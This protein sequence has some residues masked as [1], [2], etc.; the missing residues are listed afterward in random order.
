MQRVPVKHRNQFPAYL[1]S[2]N[3]TYGLRH[4]RRYPQRDEPGWRGVLYPEG[5]S[6]GDARYGEAT[7]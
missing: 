5:C 1:A 6:G 3:V 4:H 7:R 2:I